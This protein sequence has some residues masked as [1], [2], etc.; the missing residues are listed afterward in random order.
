MYNGLLGLHSLLRWLMVGLLL[1]NIL[2]IMIQS[3]ED[4]D[5]ADHRWSFRLVLATIINFVIGIYQFF[6]G[7]KGVSLL[8]EFGWDYVIKYQDLRFWVLEHPLCMFV[9]VGC[10]I[11]AHKV[12]GS[13]SS[14]SNK[15]ALLFWAIAFFFILAATPWP[16]RD[17]AIAR[18]YFR[19]LY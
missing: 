8:N 3:G 19:G 15:K 14:S 16:F 1:L 12:L 18:P 11:F 2:R 13:N 6:T 4:F 10:I 9:S 5:E 17:I 7:E